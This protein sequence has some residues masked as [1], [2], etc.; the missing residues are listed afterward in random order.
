MS[1]LPIRAKYRY[2]RT[3]CEQTVENS[4]THSVFL[5]YIDGH[6]CLVLR[7][8]FIVESFYLQV[9]NAF[10]HISSRALPCHRTKKI[11]FL[12]ELLCAG[13]RHSA[14]FHARVILV[15]AACRLGAWRCAWWAG[16][17]WR[18]SL[19]MRMMNW[20]FLE[21]TVLH[22]LCCVFLCRGRR[23]SDW[24]RWCARSERQVIEVFSSLREQ[25]RVRHVRHQMTRLFRR[26]KMTLQS[27]WLEP[28]A[29]CAF[30]LMI[31]I[32][33]T[34]SLSLVNRL[35]CA[36]VFCE[37]VSCHHAPSFFWNSFQETEITTISQMM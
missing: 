32:L 36:D 14:G 7:L 37:W 2:F 12:W 27:V 17:S 34:A 5:L 25:Q 21:V 22:R 23:K 19:E 8:C 33:I 18:E 3:I 11:L 16:C 35:C 28:S 4:P 20:V 9:R 1:G 15:G 10:P 24:G 26:T 29:W 31:I 30:R 6:P 13:F